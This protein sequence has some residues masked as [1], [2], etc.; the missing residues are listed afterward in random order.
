[1]KI[2]VTYASRHGSTGGIA[3]RIGEALEKRGFEVTVTPVREAGDVAG[4]D[5]FVIGSA[6]YAFHWMH[7]A[8]EFVRRHRSYLAERPVWLF[9]SGPLGEGDVDAKGK[10]KRVESEPKEFADFA[11]EIRPRDERV[12]FG[13]WD[14]EAKPIGLMEKLMH[15]MPAA[16]E[17]LP[18]GDFRDWAEI[19][20]WADGIATELSRSGHLVA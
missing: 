8:T 7:E 5:A 19:D 15:M 9:S 1:M 12:F 10:D 2:L 16:A 20:A 14:P 3:E 4:F 11:D 18:A 6:A 13:A 17:A